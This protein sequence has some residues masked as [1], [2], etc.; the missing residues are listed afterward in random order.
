LSECHPLPV[1]LRIEGR[2][3]LVVGG[4]EVALRKVN[5]LLDSGADVEVVAGEVVPGIE[6]LHDDKKI[7]LERRRFLPGDM[8]GAFLVYA[9]TDDPET[10]A[11]IYREALGRGVLVNVADDPALCNF[12]SG[13]V[14]KRGPLRIAVST[15][16]YCPAIAA[17]LRRELESLYPGSYGEYVT[18]SREWRKH[19]LSGTDAADDRKKEALRWL[20][21]REAF[22]LFRDF[23]KEKV[24]E[25]LERII[26]SS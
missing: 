7:R 22:M 13:A 2:K 20:A 1:F 11:S 15:S 10:N 16:G 4:G 19:V 25:E 18:L 12:F 21:S 14:V 8:D 9:A 26:S 3:C 6:R 23:G 5:D 24:W 17:G